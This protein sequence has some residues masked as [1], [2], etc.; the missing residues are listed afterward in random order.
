MLT[1]LRKLELSKKKQLWGITKLISLRCSA[2]ASGPWLWQ[3]THF[4]D[5]RNKGFNRYHKFCDYIEVCSLGIL[6]LRLV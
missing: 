1:L 3:R 5:Q 6:I 4:S 2:I